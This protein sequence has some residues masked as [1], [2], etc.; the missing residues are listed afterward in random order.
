MTLSTVF[1]KLAANS[2][3]IDAF[4]VVALNLITCWKAK[5]GDFWLNYVLFEDLGCFWGVFWDYTG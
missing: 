3:K 1:Q 5:M 4:F 2:L